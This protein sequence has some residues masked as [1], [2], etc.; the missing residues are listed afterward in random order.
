MTTDPLE[1]FNIRNLAHRRYTSNH[2]SMN[3]I[4]GTPWTVNQL[5]EDQH[6]SRWSKKLRL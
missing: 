1:C 5:L 2:L 6:G 4:L 3:L